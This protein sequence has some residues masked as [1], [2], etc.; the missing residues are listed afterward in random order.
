MDKKNAWL[1][2]TKKKDRKKVMEFAE[3]YREFLSVSKTERE[4][5]DFFAAEAEKAGFKNLDE[6]IA[7]NGTVK[8]GDRVYRT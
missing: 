4:C 2:Y 7:E 1:K 3:Q 8:A 5:T 6:I